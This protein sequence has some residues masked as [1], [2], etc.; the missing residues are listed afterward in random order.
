M[1]QLLRELADA[2]AQKQLVLMLLNRLLMHEQFS[3]GSFH[4]YPAAALDFFA[5]NP[6]AN[7]ALE[8][9]LSTD[10]I[11]TLRWHHVREV[12]TSLMGSSHPLPAFFQR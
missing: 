2:P 3:V 9:Q 6:A 12:S 7:K 10:G 8:S 4:F 1:Q 5:F 11:T